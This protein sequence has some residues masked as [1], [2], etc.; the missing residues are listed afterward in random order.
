MRMIEHRMMVEHE[1]EKHRTRMVE[2]GNEK[3][4]TGMAEHGMTDYSCSFNK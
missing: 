1:N 3:R 4:R 2:H